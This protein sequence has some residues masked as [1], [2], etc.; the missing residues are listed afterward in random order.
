[1]RCR[2]VSWR[3]G[4]GVPDLPLRE[5]CAWP[6]H[7]QMQGVQAALGSGKFSVNWVTV[8]PVQLPLFKATGTALPNFVVL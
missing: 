6:A 7:L 5:V 8:G 4:P 2:I 1:M 3:W